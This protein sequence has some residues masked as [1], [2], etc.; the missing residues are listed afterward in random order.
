VV[1]GLVFL[2]TRGGEAIDNGQVA[3]LE[4]QV[5]ALQQ[6]N[7]ALQDENATLKEENEALREARE[8]QR[9][10]KDG[11]EQYFP[12]ADTTTLQ[13]ESIDDVR[14]L[15]G[16]P[17]Y[18]ARSTAANPQN[19]REVWVYTPFEDDPTGLYLFFKGNRLDSSRQDEFPGL[20]QAYF[21]E[22]ED[23]WQN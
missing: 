2:L 11:W 17:P 15:L 20:R 18:L 1:G 21:W 16:E 12:D 4:E 3:E 13:G 6:E 14:Q 9:Q 22:D 10:P 23:F 8:I 7:T 5:A 19:N